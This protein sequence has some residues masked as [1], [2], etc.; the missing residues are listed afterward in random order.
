VFRNEFRD[1]LPTFF[2]HLFGRIR[3]GAQAT[4]T[5]EILVANHSDCIKPWAVA[6]RWDESSPS[7]GPP[8]TPGGI[9]YYLGQTPGSVPDT[10]WNTTSIYNPGSDLF[11]APTTTSPGTGYHIY[12]ATGNPCCDYG[13]VM[14]LKGD[15]PYTAMWYQEI[16]FGGGNSSA[17]YRAEVSGCHPLTIGD[18]VNVKPGVSYGPTNQGVGDLVVQDPNAIWYNSGVVP[19]DEPWLAT[20]N[21]NGVVVPADVS[22]PYGCVWSPTTGINKSPR[23]GAIPI[24]TPEDLNSCSNCDLTVENILGFFI[25]DTSGNGNNQV[26][27]GRIVTIPAS[28]DP[29]GG[30]VSDA[31]SSLKTIILVR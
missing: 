4:A 13:R 11:V 14:Q 26:V 8:P 29:T 1:A 10:D 5:A 24:I 19:A 2:A 23:I 18:Q 3:Q 17:V 22:C 31:G 9:Q 25:Q 16:D 20:W 21:P 7:A 30:T 27:E 6:D 28:Y 15:E 12:D